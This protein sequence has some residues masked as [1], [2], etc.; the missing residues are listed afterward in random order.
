MNL[1]D[2]K[3]YKDW[4]YQLS[5]ITLGRVRRFK[6]IHRGDSCYLFGD[7]V[8]LKWFDLKE[9]SNKIAIASSQLPFH[10]S[11]NELNA[12]YLV[13]TEPFWFY[14]RIIT[15]YVTN[16]VS[17][18]KLSREY[19]NI[20]RE[21]PDTQFFFNFSNYPVIRANNI[22]FLFRD[23]LDPRLPNNFISNRIP[24]FGGALRVGI[25]LAIYMG[26]DHVYLTGCDYSHLPARNLHWYEKGKGVF[27][28]HKNYEKEFFKVAKEFINIT[29]ITLDGSS[30]FIDSVTYKEHT[31]TEPIYRENTELLDDKSM[32][33][34]DT[35]HD[36]SIY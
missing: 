21:N 8:S 30:E 28:T 34:L 11:F 6:D 33:I 7:G 24:S 16:S 10:N 17:Q 29:T 23:I 1:I 9:F 12:K 22:S 13:L 25:L 19:R 3:Y 14:P 32:K 31:G 27:T 35:W 4:V 36:Y 15:D 18:P 20:V 2:K 26:F 5:K